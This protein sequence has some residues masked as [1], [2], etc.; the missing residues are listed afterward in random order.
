M[1]D[2]QYTSD[3]IR[4]DFTRRMARIFQM[5]VEL[6]KIGYQ[7]LRVS[8]VIHHNRFHLLPSL[9]MTHPGAHGIVI[10]QDWVSLSVQKSQPIYATY[11]PLD[12]QLERKNARQCADEFIRQKPFI[13]QL[14]MVD[15]YEYAGWFESLTGEVEKGLRPVVAT[16]SSDP[17]A[18]NLVQFAYDD[19]T[20][21]TPN[22]FLMGLGEETDVRNIIKT[23]PLP[24]LPKIDGTD[25]KKLMTNFI[26]GNH[27]YRNNDS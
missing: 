26:E 12:T 7:G 13:S 4:D 15:D 6:H 17:N 21:I 3:R 25:L 11:Y 19:E 23:F 16:Y 14:C 9:F 18:E 22:I 1:E 24:P 27:L 2:L 5:V 10:D 20:Q 8:P